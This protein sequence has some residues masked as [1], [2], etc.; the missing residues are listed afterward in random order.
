VSDRSSFGSDSQE[1]KRYDIGNE[2]HCA[3]MLFLFSA[4]KADVMLEVGSCDEMSWI[5]RVIPKFGV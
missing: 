5:N 3:T 1:G 4:I 2:L